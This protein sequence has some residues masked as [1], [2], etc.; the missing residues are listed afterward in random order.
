MGLEQGKKENHLSVYG[1]APDDKN[2]GRVLDLVRNGRMVLA[3]DFVSR[4]GEKLAAYVLCYG[5]TKE[6]RDMLERNDENYLSEATA[7]RLAIGID[8]SNEIRNQYHWC[9]NWKD[10]EADKETRA[11]ALGMGLGEVSLIRML[12]ES[13]TKDLAKVHHEAEKLA[14]SSF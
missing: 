10:T 1:Y 9:G 13:R 5:S 4:Y 7:L 6:V 8:F 11:L 3:K 12:R 2:T 14:F